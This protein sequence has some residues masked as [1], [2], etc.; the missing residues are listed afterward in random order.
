MCLCRSWI[1]SNCGSV[2]VPNRAKERPNRFTRMPA[3][4]I[5]SAI[6]IFVGFVVLAISLSHRATPMDSSGHQ[7]F[8]PGFPGDDDDEKKKRT[9]QNKTKKKN[10]K[11]EPAT[12]ASTQNTDC[13]DMRGS[14]EA[15]IVCVKKGRPGAEKDLEIMRK[16]LQDNKFTYSENIDPRA[17][18]ILKGFREFRDKLNENEESVSCCFVVIMA[19]GTLGKIIGSD[20]AEVSL[21]DVFDLFNNKQCSALREK[22]KV[23]IIQACRG[24][25]NRENKQNMDATEHGSPT[26]TNK[27]PKISD[28]LTVY[29]TPPGGAALRSPISGS[30]MFIEMANI[31]PKYSD[32]CDVY[33]LFT[34]VNKRLDEVDFNVLYERDK[35]LVP[36]HRD[37]ALLRNN[38]GLRN[39]VKGRDSSE[40]TLHIYSNLVKRVYLAS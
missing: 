9:G 6:V 4:L 16:L 27:L 34:K 15:H 31:F 7:T 35:E 5:V 13:Y 40:L 37:A 17:E 28:T 1:Q 39:S 10:T 14:R 36:V 12:P 8:T 23:F 19:H 25:S 21:D 18:D 22:P 33:E 30:P 26:S 20:G 3:R 32:K 2:N 24:D 38:K 29:A 11:R